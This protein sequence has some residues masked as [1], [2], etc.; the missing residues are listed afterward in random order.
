MTSFV[1]TPIK[2]F[3]SSE[4]HNL[5]RNKNVFILL[6]TKSNK[7]MIFCA[8]WYSLFCRFRSRYRDA[9]FGVNFDHFYSKCHFRA[10]W[11][12]RLNWFEVKI[13]P[14]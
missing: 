8:T 13:E 1:R 11:G 6:I 10:R 3:F 14:P 9:Y 5:H 4:G 12:S 7:S 2:R